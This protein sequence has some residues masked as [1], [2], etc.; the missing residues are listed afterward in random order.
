MPGVGEPESRRVREPSLADAII[1]LVTLVVLIAGSLLLFGLDAL[2][3]PIQVALVLC[4]LTAA[5]IAL[6]NG[7]SWDEVQHAA[8]N[9]LAS[10]ASAIFILLAVGALIGVWNLSGTIPTLIYYGIKILS[11]ALYYAASAVICGL[12]SMT[13]GSSWT[14]AGTVGVGLVGVASGIGVSSVI[15][16]GAVVSGAYLGDKL[17]PLSETTVLTAQLNEVRVEDH[18]K[19]QAWT[20]VPAFVIALAVLLVLGL[21]KGASVHAPV[22]TD[23]E[24]KK[25]GDIYHINGWN[26]LP[27]LLLGVLSFRKVPAPLA[28]L[29]S[30]LFAGVLGAFLQPQVMADFVGKD[31]GAV[32]GSIKGIWLAMANGFSINSG[33]GEIDRL[34]SRGG[35]HSMLLTVWLI[36]GAVT[37]GTLLEHFGLISRLI[38]PLIAAARSTGR[39]FLTVFAVAFGLNV[40]AGDQYIALVLPVK[41]FRREF[42]RRG[43]APFNLSRLAA[44]SATVTSPL[45]AWNSCGA[46][47][48]AVLGVSAFR[49][50]PFAI[51]CYVSPVLSVL[52]GITGFKIEKT[53]PSTPGPP[54]Q[55]GA[56]SREPT[57]AG[58][59]P[60]GPDLAQQEAAE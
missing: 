56:E 31:T 9:S 25:L 58:R 33:I 17:S 43:L 27:L 60:D 28:L 18:V 35:M 53:T 2:D 10:I 14:T 54:A 52:Y 4:V 6:K 41:V 13:I 7:H 36:I 39:L 11:P 8:Q 48:G 24:L 20:S 1:P 29:A 26:L 47:M 42:A 32:I 40:V 55:P 37:F 30:A 51:F 34:L 19:R 5:L 16:A 50:L 3:G 23:I 45:I 57:T 44:D 38:A 46:Y 21:L 49:Y 59:S 15:T 12:I 22:P